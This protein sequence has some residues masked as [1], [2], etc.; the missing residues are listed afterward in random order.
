M[1][2]S[3]EKTPIYIQ[4]HDE[5]KRRIEQGVWKIGER[6]P[7]ERELSIQFDVSRMT[8]RQ[9]VLNLAEE[10]IV[11]RRIGS[12]TYVA[13]KKVQE[14]LS[15]TTSFSELMLAQGKEPFSELISYFVTKP[16]IVECEAL[17]ITEDQ[18]VVRM[19]RVR[20]GDLIPI[21][22]EVAT[23]PHYLVKNVNKD[24]VSKHFYQTIEKLG[25]EIG[26]NSQKISASTANEKTADLLELKRGDAILRLRQISYLKDQRPFEYVLSQYAGNRFEI[27]LEK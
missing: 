9:A 25:H 6:L 3:G 17:E 16:S 12:G 15:G 13:S 24:E 23:I 20:Y 7:S 21:C 22:Y 27:L 1:M 18:W 5:L 2:D 11:E 8:L 26:G 10:G 4:I 14:K 19:E